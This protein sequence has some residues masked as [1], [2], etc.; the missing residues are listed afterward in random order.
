[1]SNVI[2]ISSGGTGGHIMPARCLAKLLSQ[3]NFKVFF[4]ADKKVTNFIKKED[5]FQSFIISASQLKKS[6]PFLFLAS[7]KI[8]FGLF[9]GR[10]VRNF[11]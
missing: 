8:F 11:F 10:S 6:A 9:S 1:M 2:F 3:N 5:S 7:I 4:L